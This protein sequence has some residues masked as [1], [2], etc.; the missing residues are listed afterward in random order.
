[1]QGCV[2]LQSHLQSVQSS[3]SHREVT[4]FHHL[5]DFTY[6]QRSDIRCRDRTRPTF[7]QELLPVSPP[8][9]GGHSR[10]Q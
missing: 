8:S 1:M 2:S 5:S 3:V 6:R 7:P 4:L 9:P 10:L